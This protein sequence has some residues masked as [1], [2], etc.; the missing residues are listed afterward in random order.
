MCLFKK[1]PKKHLPLT[2]ETQTYLKTLPTV[3]LIAC[4]AH[5]GYLAFPYSG[6]NT[7]DG[8]PLVYIHTDHGCDKPEYVLTPI[9]QTT[10]GSIFGWT[11]DAS[12]LDSD[13]KACEKAFYPDSDT[14]Q[15]G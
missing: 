9:T 10:T 6:K 8:T 15:E 4:W 5:A 3:Y 11:L 1:S 7:K 13:V 12:K 14:H 2:K